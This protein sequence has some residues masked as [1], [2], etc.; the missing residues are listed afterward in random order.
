MKRAWKVM[1]W[2]WIG[3]TSL[4]A[5]LVALFYFT[6]DS[7]CRNNV[8]AETASPDGRFRAVVFQ[9]DCGATT[10]F[11]TQVSVLAQ[12]SNLENK[13]GNV[14]VAD[15]GHGAAP[16]GPG[17]GPVVYVQWR[18]PTLLSISHHPAARVFLAEHEVHSVQ[19]QYEHVSQ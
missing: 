2:I 19:L 14:F 9:R 1:K 13:A 15:T 11:S 17:D 18:S 16:S 6:F 12:S 4:V 7:A 10:G 3:V 5:I 8:L